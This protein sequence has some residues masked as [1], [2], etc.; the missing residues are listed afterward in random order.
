MLDF[1]R[2]IHNRQILAYGFVGGAPVA[3]IARDHI[4]A[5]KLYRA[6]DAIT[7]QLDTVLKEYLRKT[8]TTHLKVLRN[9]LGD[10]AFDAAYRAGQDL[11]VT[12][13]SA[14]DLVNAIRTS[15]K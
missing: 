14:V 4:N 15:A 13:T 3:F 9:A 2:R 8:R 7:A 5:T 12:T 10:S 6:A 11:P 1:G